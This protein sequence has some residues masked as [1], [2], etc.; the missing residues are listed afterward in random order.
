MIRG[1]VVE[2]LQ[3]ADES[4]NSLLEWVTLAFRDLTLQEVSVALKLTNQTCSSHSRYAPDI[5]GL[6]TI[7]ESCGGTIQ[8]RR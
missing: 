4:A 5:E 3:C 8:T 2:G 6:Q 7:I 1:M